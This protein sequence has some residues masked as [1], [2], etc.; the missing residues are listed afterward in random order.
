[1]AKFAADGSLWIG[2]PFGNGVL[3]FIP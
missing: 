1:L 2:T 3:H